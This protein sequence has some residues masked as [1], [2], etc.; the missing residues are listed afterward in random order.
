M[1]SN[2]G[3]FKKGLIPWH[4]G[5]NKKELP[6]LSNAGAKIGSKRGT[7]KPET[8]ER[9]RKTLT[10]VKHS[11][12]RKMNMKGKQSGENHPKWKGG[13]KSYARKQALERDNYTCQRCGIN[14]RDLLEVDHIVPKILRPDLV[15]DI[16][17]LVTLCANCHKKKT[18]SEFRLK[19]YGNKK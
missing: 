6:Q 8:I 9:I 4:K 14:D 19:I 10:G 18:I 15:A 16:N 13:G 5:R 17:N 11:S 7:P 1:K 12:E 3:Q 2:S